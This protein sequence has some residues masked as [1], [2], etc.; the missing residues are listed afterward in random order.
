MLALNPNDAGALAA[1]SH[2]LIHMGRQDEAIAEAE[3][4]AALD[5]FNQMVPSFQAQVLLSARRYDDVPE[6]AG[7]SFSIV[8]DAT[9]PIIAERVIESGPCH[10]TAFTAFLG[11]CPDRGPAAKNPNSRLQIEST[12][13]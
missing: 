4:A 11:R 5:P 8:V 1:H 13:T 10:P 7:R 2:F 9:V 3:R 12:G 6:L